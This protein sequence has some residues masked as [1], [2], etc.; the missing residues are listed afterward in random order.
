MYVY[1]KCPSE[2]LQ[3][4]QNALSSSLRAPLLNHLLASLLF[5]VCINNPR[6]IFLRCAPHTD[7]TP[8]R[9][10]LVYFKKRFASTCTEARIKNLNFK[11][12][13]SIRVGCRCQPIKL[14]FSVHG[15]NWFYRLLEWTHSHTDHMVWLL[16]S[17]FYSSFWLEPSSASLCKHFSLSKR[18]SFGFCP[19]L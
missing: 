12:I 16:I 6:H 17:L 4:A 5:L 1:K 3:C 2:F 8:R 7:Q 11:S 15:I 19:S 9:N 14:E 13:R 10:D 18:R